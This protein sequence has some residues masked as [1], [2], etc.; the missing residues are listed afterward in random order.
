MAHVRSK[1]YEEIVKDTTGRARPR[2]SWGRGETWTIR[3]EQRDAQD[4]GER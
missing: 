2:V 3:D 4:S 1:G